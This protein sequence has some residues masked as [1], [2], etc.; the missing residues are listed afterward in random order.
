VLFDG[1]PIRAPREL[2]QYLGCAER[3]VRLDR[4]AAGEDCAPA[5]RGAD[6]G[7]GQRTGDVDLIEV[8]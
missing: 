3:L 4:D 8:R 5:R 1:P 2:R 7:H 6:A